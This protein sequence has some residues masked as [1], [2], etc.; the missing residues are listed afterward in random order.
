[1]LRSECLVLSSCEQRSQP[2][3]VSGYKGCRL[4]PGKLSLY[5]R[6]VTIVDTSFT[7]TNVKIRI[8]F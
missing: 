7:S 4:E 8:Y 3:V 1:M 2:G 5:N 6:R